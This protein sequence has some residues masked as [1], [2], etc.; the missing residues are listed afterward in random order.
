MARRV[1]TVV[2]LVLA[3]ALGAV[4]LWPDG[5]AVN[6]LVVRIYVFFLDLGMPQAVTPEHYAAGLNVLAF[7][8]L[9]WLG[10]AALR[11]RPWQVV[12]VLTAASVVVETAQLLPVLGREA[13]IGDV[14]CNAGGAAL[15]AL[16]A[17]VQVGRRVPREHA[18]GDEAVDERRDPARDDLG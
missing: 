10:V 14:V 11:R 1:G 8:P 6:R 18:G 13:S 15:G 17:S 3:V 4:L 16:L 12:G 5:W 7:V 2:A 9:G